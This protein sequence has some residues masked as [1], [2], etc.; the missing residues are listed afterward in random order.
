MSYLLDN[1]LFERLT[2]E[3]ID[4]CQPYKCSKDPDIDSF[5]HKDSKDN[6]EDYTLEMMGYSHCF[7]TNEN[8]PKMVCA[9]SLAN[10]TLRTDTL[11]KS[12][13]NKFNRAIPNA[14]R[15]S[16]YPA[17]LI[18][19][20][21]VFD[22]FGYNLVKEHV[23]DEMMDLIKTIAINPDNDSAAR[24]IVVDAVNQPNVIDYYKR[25][26]F[27]FL[28]KSD[29]EELECLRGYRNLKNQELFV[30]ESN[31]FR[32]NKEKPI[33]KTRLMWFDLILLKQ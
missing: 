21:C 33:C 9:F 20:L 4:R 31:G 22:G 6:F 19:Q 12:K 29:E 32:E 8:I 1:C 10:T 25:N 30:N 15:R 14:K 18:G 23:G 17:I 3:I 13:K 7:Y 27:D 28:F 24:Y 16:Q 2:P 11:S 5:F 26:G